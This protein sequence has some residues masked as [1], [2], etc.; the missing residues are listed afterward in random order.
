MTA[1]WADQLIRGRNG[2]RAVLANAITAFRDAPELDGLLWF[3]AFHQRTT[4][5]GEPPWA[6]ENG[7]TEE[8]WTDQCDR[9][10][11]NW[12]QCHGIFVPPKV[13]GQAAETVA[14]GNLFH[15]VINYLIT[16]KWDC[17]DRLDTWTITYLGVEDSPYIRAT[18]SRFLI[19]AVAR[20]MEPGCK[21]DCVPILEGPQGLLKSTALRTLFSPWFTDDVDALGSKDAAM[22]IAGV[23]CAELAELDS[24]SRG[25]ASKIKAFVSRQTDRFRPP[26]GERV[27][28][29][30]RQSVFAGT[31]N[32]N[33]YLRDE[34]G[35]RRWWPWSCTKINI[36]GLTDVRDQLWAEALARY[37]QGN[38]WW[39]DTK[40]LNGYAAEQQADRLIQDPWGETIR[41][42]V[43]GC[44]GVSVDDLL[45]HLGIP[46]QDRDQRDANRV[47][48]CLK[49]LGWQ[50]RMTRI[51]GVAYPVRR[52]HP[53]AR[54]AQPR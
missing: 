42:Y 52:Y 25:E 18:A 13:A 17:K 23:W 19:A 48:A 24:I 53:P 3:D 28:D 22:Q 38:H 54:E 47:A 2:P 11:A 16:I 36:P 45:T 51:E 5:R 27:I 41:K 20:V 6:T 29:Q 15:P 21:V 33:E 26:Y 40:E 44:E 8:A 9:L 35:G 31:V 14:R 1:A 4:L 39:L 30:K 34:T 10:A 46:Q 32:G 50:R 49:A 37:D 43:D 7:P 12:L